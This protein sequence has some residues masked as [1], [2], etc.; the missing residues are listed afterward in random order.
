MLLLID[1]V[2]EFRV[3]LSLAADAQQRVFFPA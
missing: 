1:L 3:E 2:E